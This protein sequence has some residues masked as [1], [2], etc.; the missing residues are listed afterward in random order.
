MSFESYRQYPNNKQE[1]WVA[2][3]ESPEFIRGLKSLEESKMLPQDKV[4]ILSVA[5]NLKKATLF[6]VAST[7][8]A[9]MLETMLSNLGI[10]YYQDPEADERL[11]QFALTH[12]YPV[13]E[14]KCYYIGSTPDNIIDA[15]RDAR[16]M[17]DDH[18]AF[19]RAMDF[20]ETSIQAF[21]Q[22]RQ[23]E[24]ALMPIGSE[25]MTPEEQAF[26]FFR[27][28]KDNFEEEVP[29]LE[30]IIAGTKEYSPAIYNEVISSR[31]NQSPQIEA[32]NSDVMPGL[33]E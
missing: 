28:S 6:D 19:G 7:Y 15:I 31:K 8:D 25:A 10:Y 14:E 21:E 17:P 32:V 26:S 20:P 29:W 23:G 27:F 22:F 24:D 4:L 18:A 1:N 30:Q 3:R 11:R 2:Y 13:P 12:N 9:H 16:P 33:V 5:L